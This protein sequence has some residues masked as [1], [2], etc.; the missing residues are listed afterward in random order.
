MG[1]HAASNG[2]DNQPETGVAIGR[3]RAD[4]RP[5][6]AAQ[7]PTDT[8]GAMTMPRQSRA[9]RRRGGQLPT[10]EDTAVRR[11]PERPGPVAPAGAGRRR[12]DVP[13]PVADTGPV[14]AVG[15]APVVAGR[16]GV[17][18]IP[19]E[20]PAP[21]TSRVPA[22]PAAA[23]PG[24]APVPADATQRVDAGRPS[25][26]PAAA[27]LPPDATQRVS[28]SAPA[29]SAWG[30]ASAPARPAAE[31]VAPAR[32]EPDP[33]P[34]GMDRLAESRRRREALEEA[35]ASVPVPEVAATLGGRAAQR[36]E[37]QAADAARRKAEKAAGATR[38]GS[39]E[40]AP[41]EAGGVTRR[42]PRR[43]ALGALAVVLVALTVLSVWSFATPGTQETSAQTPVASSAPAGAPSSVA[44][45]PPVAEQVV[46]SPPE[47]PMG[48]VRAPI[49]VLNS[50]AINGLAGDLGE[51][52]SGGGW[53]VTG[54]GA[55]PGSDIA[56][57]TVYF[58][59]GDP[60]Q[61]EAASQLIEQF[62][63][64]TGPAARFFEVPGQPAPGLVV[65][66]TG[67]WRP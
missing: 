67:N 29:E 42:L 23:V 19:R 18:P 52:F 3:R 51:Q 56:V 53:E 16:P 25:R 50:T 64:L 65:V 57:T 63:D 39:V 31:P 58:T 45:A 12:T 37:R 36:A 62:P 14:T 8:D 10:P 21:A 9:E 41:D 49:T 5:E 47:V 59:A 4:S 38:S 32:F 30:A 13:P 60:V 44:P 11:P 20:V 61:E 17:P 48:P 33:E 7:L 34:A 6:A 22:M 2:D 1:R 54:T 43:A 55:Y 35:G 66:A 28:G 27:P 26:R 24:R 15:G 46:P 40:A